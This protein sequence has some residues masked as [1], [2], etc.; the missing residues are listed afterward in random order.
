MRFKGQN[1]IAIPVLASLNIAQT[2]AYY[3]KL[4]FDVI[5][6]ADYAIARRNTLEIHFWLCN[7]PY[8]CENTSCYIRLKDVDKLYEE[9]AELGIV[10]TKHG[11]PQVKEWGLKEFYIID[12][13][14]NLLKFGEVVSEALK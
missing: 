10:S 14:G 8:I 9:Y 1:D 4:G 7:D 3:E 2:V 5:P 13:C 6:F 11:K 12:N